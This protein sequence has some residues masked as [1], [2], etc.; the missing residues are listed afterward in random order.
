MPCEYSAVQFLQSPLL[1]R[2]QVVEMSQ[3]PLRRRREGSAKPV[4][5]SSATQL[6]LQGNGAD[7]IYELL[8]M[9]EEANTMVDAVIGKLKRRIEL[10][11]QS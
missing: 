5:K 6:D 7:G 3:Y 1:S 4:V 10:M 8:L 11:K 9:Q 2:Q